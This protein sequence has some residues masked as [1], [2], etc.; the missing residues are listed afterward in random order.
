MTQLYWLR[1]D[2]RSTDNT[3]LNAA[4]ANGVPPAQWVALCARMAHEL[5]RAGP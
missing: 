1:N 2:L 5:G 3:A 4:M